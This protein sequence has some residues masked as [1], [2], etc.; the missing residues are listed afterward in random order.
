M[1]SSRSDWR[2]RHDAVPESIARAL[3]ALSERGVRIYLM[4][5][6]R[7]FMIGQTFCCYKAC[8]LLA[9]PSVVQLAASRYC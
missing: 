3:H 1:T 5:G 6:N 4:H 7:D 2:R 9:D 8:K